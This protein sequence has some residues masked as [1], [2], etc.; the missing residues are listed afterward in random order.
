MSLGRRLDVGVESTD[1]RRRTGRPWIVKDLVAGRYKDADK[2][3]LV[4]DNL[5]THTAGSL[6]EAFEPE[7]VRRIGA[8]QAK[9]NEKHF[10]ADGQFAADD[11]KVT[12]RRP[13]PSVTV[14]RPQRPAPSGI[15]AMSAGASERRKYSACAPVAFVTRAKTVFHPGRS[16]AGTAWASAT[17]GP[18]ELSWKI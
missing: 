6:Y 5:N 12:L 1:G 8:W 3:V 15:L 13:Y 2:V 7:R 17:A 18:W 11:A 9:R 16:V 4:M 10:R 14:P